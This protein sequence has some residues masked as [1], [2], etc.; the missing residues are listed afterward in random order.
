MIPVVR[1]L[2]KI[3]QKLNKV[4]SLQNQFIP[5]EEKILAI[6]EAQQRLMKQKIGQNNIYQLG[7]DSFRSRYENLQNFIVQYEEVLPS[8]TMEVLPSYQINLESLKNKYYLPVDIIAIS[9][10]GS[11]ENREIFVNRIAKHSDLTTLIRNNHYKP[12]FRY[13]ESLAVIS[14]NSLIV[15]SDDFIINKILF[16]YLRFPKEVDIEGYIK[17]DGTESLTQDCEFGDE[18]E[19]ELISLTVEQLAYSIR[20]FDIAQAN[21]NTKK[22]SEN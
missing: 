12:D 16:S 8:K 6:N 22:E 17:L 13:Q 14:N 19:D 11:C 9:S 18:L 3:D 7:F 10:R 15:Y 21:M 2:H 5:D 4:A 1:L 20:D